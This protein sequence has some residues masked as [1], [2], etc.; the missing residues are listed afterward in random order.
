M[1]R[2]NTYKN[3]IT[4]SLLPGILFSMLLAA[5]NNDP[6]QI[7]AL[8][9]HSTRQEDHAHNVTGIYSLD[10]KVKMRIFAH[11]FVRNESTRRP[12]IDMN[13]GLKMEFFNDSGMIDNTLTADSS[14][15]Y[16]VQQD[17]IVWDSVQIVTRKGEQLNTQEL[18]WNNKAQKFFT[19]QKVRI[20]TPTQI[21][22]GTGMEANSDFSW[23]QI[24][25]PEGTVQVEKKEV[26]Q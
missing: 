8:T 3:T 23:Y 7:K 24:T 22:Y 12:Y 17:F 10:G 25:H 20:T 18:I 1:G 6:E 15:Y 26:P 5:C 13:N 4:R 11:E 19:E 14:R 9:T 21:L 16:E 2:Y